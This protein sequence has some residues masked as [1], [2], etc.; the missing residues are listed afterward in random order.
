[1][2][3]LWRA[4]GHRRQNGYRY[5]P[6]PHVVYVYLPAYLGLPYCHLHDPRILDEYET[7]Y[8]GEKKKPGLEP[9]NEIEVGTKS[10][11]L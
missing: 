8:A 11:R 7:L 3:G 2:E 4:F 10:G 5:Q 9:V 6:H 1:M